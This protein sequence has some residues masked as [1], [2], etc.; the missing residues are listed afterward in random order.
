MECGVVDEHTVRQNGS[1]P[2][3][4]AQ[5]PA[6]GASADAHQSHP[7]LLA[8]LDTRRARVLGEQDMKFKSIEE[9]RQL[10]EWSRSNRLT[11]LCNAIAL[12]LAVA[13][14]SGGGIHN[15]GGAIPIMILAY[16]LSRP[17]GPI[18]LAGFL[19]FGAW[20]SEY[21]G[22]GASPDRSMLIALAIGSIVSFVGYVGYLNSRK[23]IQLLDQSKRK[24]LIGF[25]PLIYF[26]AYIVFTLLI[27]IVLNFGTPTLL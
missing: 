27:A 10:V 26:V 8:T 11:K 25:L 9:S 17:T 14:V 6:G 7:I 1:K 5:Q 15:L 13:L 3:W 4:T 21:R 24:Y 12:G 20:Y 2:F 19:A 22:L 23:L 18:V 16:F